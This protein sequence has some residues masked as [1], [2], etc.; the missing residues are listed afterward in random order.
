MNIFI[1]KPGDIGFDEEGTC[2]WN[3][4]EHTR[5]D[6]ITYIISYSLSGL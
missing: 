2:S 3:I 4:R 1:Y 5:E 6:I